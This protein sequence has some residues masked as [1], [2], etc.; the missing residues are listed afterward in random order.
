M[1]LC[2]HN[3]IPHLNGKHIASLTPGSDD[4]GEE[5][6]KVRVLQRSESEKRAGG[7]VSARMQLTLSSMLRSAVLSLAIQSPPARRTTTNT[8]TTTTNRRGKRRLE[9]LV[10]QALQG[11][12]GVFP[13]LKAVSLCKAERVCLI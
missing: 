13:F 10:P 2:T 1:A 7:I 3:N 6:S 12:G 8:T 9:V 5:E 4:D 11:G